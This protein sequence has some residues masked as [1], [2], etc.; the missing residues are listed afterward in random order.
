MMCVG[1]G[2]GAG[3][4][5]DREGTREG[6]DEEGRV[7][8][9]LFPHRPQQWLNP[10]PYNG[11]LT[12]SSISSTAQAHRHCRGPQHCPHAAGL[13][14][15]KGKKRN[16]PS[17]KERSTRRYVPAILGGGRGRGGGGEGGEGDYLLTTRNFDQPN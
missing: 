5:E 6:S 1:A 2:G 7:P 9:A 3:R 14:E 10:K 11:P 12:W 8:G 16:V 4:L 15:N 13:G 17:P